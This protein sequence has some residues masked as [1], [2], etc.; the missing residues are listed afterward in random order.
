MQ[1]EDDAKKIVTIYQFLEIAKV[2]ISKNTLDLVNKLLVLAKIC[3][4]V[5]RVL[6]KDV[7]IIYDQ[8]VEDPFY[9]LFTF[10]PGSFPSC[11]LFV[12]SLQ[13]I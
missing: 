10:L 9:F 12:T 5:L 7:V 3:S 8:I 1:A 11:F 13:M 4:D 2:C 6:L